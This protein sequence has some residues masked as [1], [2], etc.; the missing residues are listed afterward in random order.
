MPI[1]YVIDLNRR[2]VLTKLTGVLT[3]QDLLT[4]YSAVRSD[5][6]FNADYDQLCDLSD[7][8]SIEITS[9]EMSTLPYAVPFAHASYHALIA[10]RP[11]IV[12]LA[13]MFQQ[14]SP[15]EARTCV[16]ADLREAEV[17]L[18]KQ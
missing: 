1:T 15:D 12:G 5:P 16:F 13:R 10:A 14:W 4:H 11:A 9:R 18:I 8:Q 6:A 2:C 17:W 7:I 3:A